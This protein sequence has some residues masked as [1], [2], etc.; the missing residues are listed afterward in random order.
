MELKEIGE[1][2]LYIVLGYLIAVG[3]QKGLGYAL[4]TDYP[5]VAVVSTSMQHDNPE[6][7][8]GWFVQQNFTQEEMREWGFKRG[9]I[10]GDIVVVHGA[11]FENLKVGDVIVYKFENRPPIIHRIV[12][13]SKVGNET[14]AYTKG[15]NNARM[16]Q[17]LGMP[18]IGE[19]N[20]KG[21]AVAHAPLL[22]WVKII[23]MTL[24]GR[25]G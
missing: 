4:D 11:L 6:T 10:K 22:G 2:I 23:F 25:S 9:M 18:P 16:D 19:K 21:R 12:G 20:V 15:D 14:Y 3:A 8:R 1:I 17:E 13:M 7:Y 5:I 24:T